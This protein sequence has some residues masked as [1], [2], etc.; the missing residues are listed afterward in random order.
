MR[1]RRDGRTRDDKTDMEAGVTESESDGGSIRV[2]FLACEDE[3]GLCGDVFSMMSAFG[4]TWVEPVHKSIETTCDHS[5][6]AE[7]SLAVS[8]ISWL[9]SG[10]Y[11]VTDALNKI[12]AG[13]VKRYSVDFFFFQK[14]GIF[15]KDA[16]IVCTK[17]CSIM[18]R[19][20]ATTVT[21]TVRC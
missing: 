13:A 20:E 10:M 17:T 1:Q 7:E 15:W 4:R 21:D 5:R 19:I 18:N 14:E 3:P 8:S 12:Q 6:L 2:V 9:E 11:I 16:R